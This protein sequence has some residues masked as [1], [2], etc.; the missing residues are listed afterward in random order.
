MSY[1]LCTTG[2]WGIVAGPPDVRPRPRPAPAENGGGIPD[3]PA[4][5]DHVRVQRA[6]GSRVRAAPADQRGG[7]A[8]PT[9]G[10]LTQV[11]LT[12]AGDLRTGPQRRVAVGGGGELKTRQ[13]LLV[14]EGG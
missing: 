9:T 7:A 6:G 5:P 10:G 2:A 4:G 3:Q 1:V 14:R 13:W 8:P 12:A 11:D